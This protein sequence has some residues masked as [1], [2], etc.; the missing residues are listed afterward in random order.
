MSTAT[1]RRPAAPAPKKP[2]VRSGTYVMLVA[3]VAVLNVIGV[4]MVLSASSVFSIDGHGSAWYTFMR[5]LAWTSLGAVGF[6]V[7]QRVDYRRWRRIVE[8][9]VFVTGLML[10]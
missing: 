1:K 7:A 4:V 6:A 3:T 2:T 10:L 9:L 8:P 5:Q